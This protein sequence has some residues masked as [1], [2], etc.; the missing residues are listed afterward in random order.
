MLIHGLD[1]PGAVWQNLAPALVKDGYNVWLMHYPN[2]QP[3]VD[4]AYL[5]FMKLH[6]LKESGVNRLCIVAHSMGGLVSR[7]MLTS[8]AI[9][10]KTSVEKGQ[11]PEVINLIMIGTPNH[12]SQLARFRIVT[13]MRGMNPVELPGVFL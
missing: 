1:D 11:V 13:E 5:F 7:E 6:G 4:S 12:G 3:I 8:P 9:G 10:Y 2:D